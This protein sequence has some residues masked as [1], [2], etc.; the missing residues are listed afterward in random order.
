M[1]DVDVGRSRLLDGV[2]LM[3]PNTDGSCPL[4]SETQPDRYINMWT[5]PFG[6]LV[7]VGWQQGADQEVWMDVSLERR[8]QVAVVLPLVLPNVPPRRVSRK[9]APSLFVLCEDDRPTDLGF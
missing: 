9:W 8:T 4:S 3:A 5:G 6:Q 7:F 1:N 2:Q